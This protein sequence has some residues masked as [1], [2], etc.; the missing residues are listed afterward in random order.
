MPI[1]NLFRYWTY[2][3]FTPGTVLR[4]KYEA[5]KRLIDHDRQAHDHLASLEDLYYN[6][7]QVDFQS[8]VNTYG[9]FSDSVA[10][11]VDE[12]LRMC[13]MGYWSL[14]DYYKKFDFYVR[15]MLAPPEFDFSPPFVLALGNA[16]SLD[17]SVAGAKAAVLNR[18]NRELHLPVPEGFVI[19]TRAFHFFLEANALRPFINRQLA[20]LD[21]F[22]P[23]S[24]ADTA[25]KIE[26]AIL[27]APLPEELSREIETA[28]AH[29][30]K[31]KTG[32]RLAMR[33][34]AV[35][36]DGRASFAGQYRSLM[37]V[38]P[39]NAGRAYKQIIAGKYSAA[40]LSYRIRCGIP[41]HETP[42][43][44]LVLEMLDAQ[45]AGVVYTRDMDNPETGDL[46]IHSAWGLGGLV[47]DGRVTPDLIRVDRKGAITQRHT[48]SKQQQLVLDGPQGPRMVKTSDDNQSALSLNTPDILTLNR[49]S[50][51]LEEHF[52]AP[53]DIEWCLNRDGLL[54]LLQSRPLR[55]P[56]QTRQKNASIDPGEGLKPVCSGGRTICRG[57]A[58][59]P[60]FYLK[61]PGQM[62]DIP[63]NSIVAAPFGLPQYVTA[64]H[65]MAG[66]ILHTGS[67]A[68]H[69]ASIA[70]EFGL[71]AMVCADGFDALEPGNT[72]TLDADA[73]RVFKGKIDGLLSHS[74]Q[75]FQEDEFSQSSFMDKLRFTIRFCADL[76]LTDPDSHEFGPDH[77]RS[78]HDIIRFAHETAMRE[79]FFTGRRKGSRKKG[80]KQLISGL[81][82]LLYILD[83]GRE[84]DGGLS[85]ANETA[86]RMDHLASIPMKALLRG[87]S[88]PDICW[89]ETTHFDWDA[90]DKI[91]MAGG[92]ISADSPQF[93][94]YA[95]VARTYMNV[96][97]R[98]GYHFVIL[99]SR[100]TP[101]I[102]ENYILFRF[103]GGG[104]N[105]NGRWLRAD[106]I[107]AV[108]DR[109]G[110][111]T[112]ITCDLIDARL[113]EKDEQTIQTTLELT[114]RLLGATKLMDM[115]LKN[116]GDVS[117]YVE[118]FMKGRYDFRSFKD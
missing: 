105:E 49:W 41:D 81:P 43:A 39:L 29:F 80:A 56:Q 92:I 116:K 108:L 106:F 99:D 88:H 63:E 3:V 2:Q 37:N 7:K 14:K 65:K 11:M 51:K 93:G 74:Q 61:H 75:R 17:E 62:G 38:D 111:V 85:A 18:L 33:S 113:M 48:G 71:P 30:Q 28:L 54:F 117:R 94:S 19:T 64:I 83:V 103:S 5:F 114:G 104:G 70:R 60:V 20:D 4:E 96:N 69:F 8:V 35:K 16:D 34:S 53:Q 1:K 97:L 100:C 115:Y 76:K 25:G 107:G 42:M 77:C 91:V 86:L 44:V 36:E 59:G 66:I 84:N 21:I 13:P 32:R 118:E 6:K 95:V 24:L 68:G 50:R 23:V 27:E 57:R 87:L 78:L 47:V 101:S 31:D 102:E 79:M 89:D 46:L 109:L 9:E 98:F 72:V 52:H 22:D 12:L 55:N 58:A 90:Y 82:M 112:Q 26:N 10:G 110:F 73:G 67:T 40:A 45:A 15:F